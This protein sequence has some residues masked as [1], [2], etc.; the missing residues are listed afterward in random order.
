MAGDGLKQRLAEASLSLNL[1]NDV[2]APLTPEERDAARAVLRTKQGR[3][4]QMVLLNVSPEV[5]T[6]VMNGAVFVVN[7]EGRMKNINSADGDHLFSPRLRDGGLS[8]ATA[9]A[10]ALFDRRQEALPT[11]RPRTEWWGHS[12]KA[13]PWSI[14]DSDA[15]PFVRKGRNV[16]HG[17]A[18]GLRP[19]VGTR[20]TVPHRQRSRRIAR[21]WCIPVHLDRTCEHEQRHR[22]ETRGGVRRSA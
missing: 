2:H 11:S 16:F 9:G 14:V 21:P 10:Q 19:V 3:D 1:S 22:R 4:K 13:P 7:R 5:A 18:L 15:E 12:G 20:R 17:F 6:D 8:M